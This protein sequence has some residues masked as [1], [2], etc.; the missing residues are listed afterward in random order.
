MLAGST[1]CS[2]AVEARLF[3]ILL[4]HATMSLRW[5]PR[6]AFR[7]C[8]VLSDVVGPTQ[9]SHFTLGMRVEP[10]TST[11][12]CTSAMSSPASF[13]ALSTGPSVF[14]NRSM[15]SYDMQTDAVWGE[16][17]GR[18]H[19]RLFRATVSTFARIRKM[20]P[21]ALSASPTNERYLFTQ[22]VT[23]TACETPYPL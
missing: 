4:T 21:L 11:T 3:R 1:C 18:R 12:S 5:Q 13:R 16:K 10:P 22:R 8:C 2:E 19:S 17:E 14:L 23:H 6:S 9:K 20:R 7:V 15:L